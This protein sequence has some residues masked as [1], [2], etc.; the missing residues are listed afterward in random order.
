MSKKHTYL[1][2]KRIISVEH[3]LDGKTLTICVSASR[4]LRWYFSQWQFEIC[5]EEEIMA[6]EAVLNVPGVALLLPL[7]WLTGSDLQVRCLD[8]VFYDATQALQRD[9]HAMYPKMPCGTRL[10]V[11][12]LIDSPANPEGSAMLFSG[13]LDATYSFYANRHLKPRLIQVFGTEFPGSE[14]RFLNR[15]VKESNVFADK[16][17]VEISFVHTNFFELF[18]TRAVYHA[19]S[20]V[21]E[22]V[23]G[24]WWKGMGYALGFLAMTAPLSAGRFNHLIIAAWANQEH[25]DRM[26]E[27]PDASSPRIDQKIAWSNLRVE[28]HGCLHRYEKVQAMKNWLPGNQLR[29]CWV[30][31]QAVEIDGALNCNRCEKCARSIVALVLGGADPAR[32]G[33]T[34]NDESIRF[35]KDLLVKKKLSNKHLAMWW[36][37]MQR[38]VP[39]H[40]KG[41]MFGLGE[42]LEWF[43][44]FDLGNGIDKQLP[45]WT[46]PRLYS[47]APYP[48]AISIRS[49]VYGILGEPHWVNKKADK[50]TREE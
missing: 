12:E 13:G 31:D 38:M 8:R 33:L 36:G 43:R 42:F 17:G 14:T 18:D 28:H 22:L 11:G 29:V 3:Q 21:R 5:Y 9:Y 32:C 44:N 16:H 20:R 7:A 19:F 25:A 37:P 35:M 23:N 26:R 2:G 24:T 6:D 27:N 41:D 40:I 10:I 39:E 1:P 47:M 49:L 15:V 46:I 34:V 4:D 48:V 50:K 45:I 30:F